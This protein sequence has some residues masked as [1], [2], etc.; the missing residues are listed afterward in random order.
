MTVK[1]AA[2]RLGCSQSCVKSLI[3]NRKLYAHRIL[4]PLKH[5]FYWDIPLRE[6]TRFQQVK[7][8]Q[9]GWPRGRRRKPKEK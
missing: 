8:I 6:I 1:E 9:R 3:A 5:G 4:A 7:T 2:K